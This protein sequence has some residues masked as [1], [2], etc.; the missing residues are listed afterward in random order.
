MLSACGMRA[1][2][3]KPGPLRL[4]P[5]QRN[6]SSMIRWPGKV[7]RHMWSRSSKGSLGKSANDSV[8]TIVVRGCGDELGTVDLLSLLS[9]P[10]VTS[11]VQ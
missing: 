4:G 3:Q 10:P 7:A 11:P 1:G 6:L 9:R 8:L 2:D 5:L